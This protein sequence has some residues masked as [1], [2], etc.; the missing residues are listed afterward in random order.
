[1]GSYASFF[2]G[3]DIHLRRLLPRQ[4]T[5]LMRT[6]AILADPIQIKG[7]ILCVTASGVENHEI[8]LREE[9]LHSP[10]LDERNLR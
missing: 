8:L 1:M 6:A 4:T 3:V 5:K 9:F 2:G 7:F 10:A